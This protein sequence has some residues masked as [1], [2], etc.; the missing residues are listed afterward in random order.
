MADDLNPKRVPRVI[1]FVKFWGAPGAFEWI[2]EWQDV[3]QDFASPVLVVVG[4]CASQV[5]RFEFRVETTER[6][7]NADCA[8][9]I[10]VASL[11]S[12]SSGSWRTEGLPPLG[13]R[14][15]ACVCRVLG[16]ARIRTAYLTE[17][18]A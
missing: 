3:P 5:D 1:R 13:P 6:P 12:I 14:V 17:R 11:P 7:V 10:E 9:V 18:V 15:R 8:L 2:T 4:Q 16:C